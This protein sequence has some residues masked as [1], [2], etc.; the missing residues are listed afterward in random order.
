MDSESTSHIILGIDEVGRGPW[1]GPLVVGAA[2]LSPE[3]IALLQEK[4]AKD[5]VITSCS[6]QPSKSTPEKPHPT[7]TPSSDL[8]FLVTHLTDSKKLTAKTRG[9]LLPLIQQYAAT[10]TGWVSAAELDIRGLSASLKLATRRAV[11]QLLAAKTPFTEIIIDGTI[12]FL[13]DTP[14]TDHVTT[15]PKADALIPAVSAASIVA[16][17][18]RDNYMVEIATQYPLYG[19]EKHVGYGTALHKQSL[20]EHG[21]C[22][23]HR[24]SFRPIREIMN[25]KPSK[26]PDCPLKSQ[27]NDAK[28]KP[29]ST[30]QKGQTA[31]KSVASYL[32]SQNHQ[33]L[34]HNFKAKSY[35]IDL[36]SIKNQQIFFTEVK[37]SQNPAPEGTPLVRV[38][39]QKQQQ[40]HYGAECF[41]N[42][43]PEYQNFNPILAAASVS[44]PNFQ[45]A[46]WFPLT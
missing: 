24:K 26:Y 3:L 7:S 39:A 34:A 9:K 1:A 19:F 25:Q 28:S 35:E 42:S 43:H 18:A 4:S 23:E 21:I 5:T 30:S 46:D 33:I 20:L 2:I 8:E 36:I 6:T 11:K 12:N 22:P 15:L 45:V 38:T 10:A 29:P 16:K 32:K 31:E 14:L 41:L 37:Y 27:G 17:V 44:G 40:M 13:D